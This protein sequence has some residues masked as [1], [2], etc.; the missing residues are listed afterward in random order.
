MRATIDPEGR[1]QLGEEVQTQLG[2]KPGDEVVLENHNGTWVIKSARSESGL[3]WEGNVLVHHG[4]GSAPVDQAL[5]TLREKRL[6]DL[7]EGLGG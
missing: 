4:T 2:L 5:A 6:L 1:I 7:S 3:A